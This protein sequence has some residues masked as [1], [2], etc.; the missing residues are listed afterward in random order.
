MCLTF[1]NQKNKNSD[2][3]GFE[4]GYMILCFVYHTSLPDKLNSSNYFKTAN[5]LISWVSTTINQHRKH[6]SWPCYIIHHAYIHIQ[7]PELDENKQN[8]E[9]KTS[10]RDQK[11]KFNVDREKRERA[12]LW[13]LYSCSKLMSFWEEEPA[14]A[15]AS[16]TAPKFLL[17]LQILCDNID[18]KPLLLAMEE[19]CSDLCYRF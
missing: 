1:S 17:P 7:S 2:L 4:S 6:E 19:A 9:S 13:A 15:V 5:L 10:K 12:H 16:G 8:P 3:Q 11:L 14:A 18:C